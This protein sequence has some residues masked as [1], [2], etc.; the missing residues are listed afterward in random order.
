MS[1]LMLRWISFTL[2]SSMHISTSSDLNLYPSQRAFFKFGGVSLKSRSS[3]KPPNVINLL[4]LKPK[5]HQF[6]RCS[7]IWVCLVHFQINLIWKKKMLQLHHRH[8]R[9]PEDQPDHHQNTISPLFADLVSHPSFARTRSLVGN[10][11]RSSETTSSHLPELTPQTTSDRDV[12]YGSS[13][14]CWILNLIMKRLYYNK[15]MILSQVSI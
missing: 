4:D 6:L 8:Q 7:Q 5:T 14:F 2:C 13:L 3:E 1:Q 10:I 15:T 11:H 12:F 9:T